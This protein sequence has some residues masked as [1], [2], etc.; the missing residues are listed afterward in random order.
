MSARLLVA[1]LS[2]VVALALPARG[3]R[4]QTVRVDSVPPRATL[5]CDGVVVGVTPVA[6]DPARVRACSLHARDHRALAVDPEALDRAIV[7]LALEPGTPTPPEPPAP[8]PAPAPTA[9]APASRRSS[10]DPETGLLIPRFSD[11]APPRGSASRE[12][13]AR[14]CGTIEPDT[15]LMVPCFGDESRSHFTPP[16]PPPRRV[17]RRGPRRCGTVDPDTGL[18]HP[19]FQ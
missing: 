10:F 1:G 15:G 9:P 12:H 5:V 14:R 13:P 2:V 17:R 16:P 3:A 11:D 8:A 7:V 19:C 18:I 4:A 6:V